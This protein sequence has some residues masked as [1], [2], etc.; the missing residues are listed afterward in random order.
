MTVLKEPP[1]E[2]CAEGLE[3]CSNAGRRPL[4][5]VHVV[6]SLR[7]G[8]LEQFVVR[9][10][11]EQQRAGHDVAIFGVEGGP[12]LEQAREM[13]LRAFTS[14][15]GHAVGHL[16]RAGACLARLRPEIAHAHNPGALMYALLAKLS[17]GAQVVMTRHGQRDRRIGTALHWR[18]TDAVV[19]VSEA[20]AAAMRAKY[21]AYAE[22]V[23]VIINGVHSPE[24]LPRRDEVRADLG[25]G[26]AVVGIIV[27][28]LDRL[29]G[30]D[31]LLRALGLLR[32]EASR[33]VLL[34]AGDGPERESL[35][36]LAGELKLAPEQVRFLGFRTDVSDLLSAADFF[37]LP[38]HTEGLPLSVLE[39]MAHGLPVVATPVGGIPEIVTEGESGILVPVDEPEALART[40]A[41]L[42]QDAGLRRSMGEAGARAAR[43]R[44]SFDGMARQY[45]A[46]YDQLLSG[47]R[48][49]RR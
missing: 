34:V 41:R 3:R 15:A 18:G 24:G 37:A 31:A 6:T 44:F 26:D 23:S 19:A 30:H 27:A 32:N 46:L 25:L 13:G 35:E 4:R 21:P 48:A 39:A 10:A 5:I 29:K 2:C 7:V 43:E 8:G 28:R 16:A 1:G 22:R 20:V 12:L 17:F 11:A 33:V 38:S 40:I 42:V 47:K 9:I 45:E 49:K 36:R 14:D